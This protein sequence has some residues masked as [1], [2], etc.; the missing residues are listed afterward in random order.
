MSARGPYDDMIEAEEYIKQVE[1][2]KLVMQA[3]LT[4]DHQIDLHRLLE[5]ERNEKLYEVEKDHIE[6]EALVLSEI[7]KY[8]IQKW[9]EEELE[10]LKNLNI[11]NKNGSDLKIQEDENDNDKDDYTQSAK[12]FEPEENPNIKDIPYF[13]D[14]DYE[15]K[16]EHIIAMNG[17]GSNA[18][19]NEN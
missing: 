17:K 10:E 5:K 7:N 4:E 11:S 6:N 16:D 13:P 19:D 18:N 3:E 9:K 15:I 2:R 8:K 1:I 14:E 12:I